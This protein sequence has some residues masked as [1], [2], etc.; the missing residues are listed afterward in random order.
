[1]T[2]NSTLKDMGKNNTQQIESEKEY[3]LSDIVRG[4]YFPFARDIRT[5]RKIVKQDF[6]GDNA[7]RAMIRGGG[8]N[9]E[10]RIQGANII[11][12]V[13]VY[14]PGLMI[15]KRNVK[16]NNTKRVSTVSR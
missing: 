2:M 16:R 15:F 12:F 14:G 7:L 3:C 9:P 8:K 10:Y 13:E 6:F 4:G 5:V 11:K 1:M